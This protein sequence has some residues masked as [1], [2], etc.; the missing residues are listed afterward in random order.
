MK[1][2]GLRSLPELRDYGDVFQGASF[3]ILVTLEVVC[4]TLLVAILFT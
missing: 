3:S 2:R 1:G 4:F